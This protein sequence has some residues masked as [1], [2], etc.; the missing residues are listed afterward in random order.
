MLE[1]YCTFVFL[2]GFCSVKLTVTNNTGA[3]VEKYV[4]CHLLP[5]TKYL[6]VY[7]FGPFYNLLSVELKDNNFFVNRVIDPLCTLKR[8][9]YRRID[10]MKT[11]SNEKK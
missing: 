10:F 11:P 3:F 1:A 8:N 2:W 7:I 9:S 6:I 4:D 5:M